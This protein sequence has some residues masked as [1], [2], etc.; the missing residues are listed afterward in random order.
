[1]GCK[2]IR[3]RVVGASS[4]GEESRSLTVLGGRGSKLRP[5]R[6][7]SKAYYTNWNMRFLTLPDYTYQLYIY[8][9]IYIYIEEKIHVYA[10]IREKLQRW[11]ARGSAKGTDNGGSPRVTVLAYGVAVGTR[12]RAYVLKIINNPLVKSGSLSRAYTL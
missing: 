7:R 3:N 12:E 9:C 11:I 4:C 2:N 10:P 8:I 5:L 1:M 6:S